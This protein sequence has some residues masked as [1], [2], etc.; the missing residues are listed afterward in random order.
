GLLKVAHHGGR[1]SSTAPFLQAVRPGIAVIS[2][3]ARNDYGHPTEQA[4]GRLAQAGARVYRTDLLGDVTVRSR[5]GTSWT[6]ETSQPAGASTE[7]RAPATPPAAAKAPEPAADGEVLGS[8]RS[9]V[10]HRSGCPA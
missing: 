10:F 7:A 1:F 4:L 9:D 5:D 8:A 2:V 6:V 3:G